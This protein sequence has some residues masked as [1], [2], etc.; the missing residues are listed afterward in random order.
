VSELRGLGLHE[1]APEVAA[2]EAGAARGLQLARGG[3]LACSGRRCRRRKGG[4]AGRGHVWDDR[5]A[6]KE[7]GRVVGAEQRRGRSGF[8]KSSGGQSKAAALPPNIC[9][10][11]LQTLL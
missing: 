9:S 11:S 6:G 2:E 8:L 7:G 5:T 3:T 4:G 10:L 1:A